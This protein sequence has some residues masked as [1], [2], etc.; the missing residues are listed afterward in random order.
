MQMY[1]ARINLVYNQM[2]NIT[3]DLILNYNSIVLKIRC[4]F[5]LIF[6]YDI[7]II[8]VNFIQI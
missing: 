5:I 3:D 7:N 2:I 1:L 4:F 6:N 8:C